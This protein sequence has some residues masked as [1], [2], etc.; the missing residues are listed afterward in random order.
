MIGFH[1]CD[2]NERNELVNN[3]NKIIKSKEAYDWLGNGFYVWENNYSRALKWATDK[4]KRDEH[5]T[6]PSV[7]GVVYQ[8]EHCLD[9]TDSEFIDILR[10]YHE[11]L[12]N[13]LQIFKYNWL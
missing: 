4:Q 5:I 7:V 3:P 13:D 2:E 8:L 1:G 11:L 9:L 6:K 10:E 12:K